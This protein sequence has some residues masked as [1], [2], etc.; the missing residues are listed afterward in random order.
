MLSI[1]GAESARRDAEANAAKLRQ[2]QQEADANTAKLRQAQQEADA[3]SAKLEQ[4][5]QA[6]EAKAAALEQ[7]RQEAVTKEQAARKSAEEAA[8]AAAAAERQAASRQA[9]AAKR[10]EVAQPSAPAPAPLQEPIKAGSPAAERESSSPF[11]A[12]VRL[13]T[14]SAQ[15]CCNGL[16]GWRIVSTR[17]SAAPHW[18]SLWRSSVCT[19]S[20]TC[21]ALVLLYG[22]LQLFISQNQPCVSGAP[23]GQGSVYRACLLSG[24]TR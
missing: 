21:P 19:I 4:A 14:L 7:E 10:P 6:A 2:A 22:C 16:C 9:E 12:L 5:R 20:S 3:K 11:S 1:Q 18:R 17:S 24:L 8:A 23:S 15:P 13:S